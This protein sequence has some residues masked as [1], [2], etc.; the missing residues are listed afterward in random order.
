MPHVQSGHQTGRRHGRNSGQIE[1]KK[2]IADWALPSYSFD[3]IGSN[4]TN[5]LGFRQKMVQNVHV[6][7]MSSDALHNKKELWGR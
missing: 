2:Q 1:H 3:A 7:S 5:M 4:R 6:F